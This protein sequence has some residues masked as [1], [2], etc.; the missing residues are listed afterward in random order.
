MVMF[1]SIVRLGA[2]LLALYVPIVMAQV[3][4]GMVV[5][6]I[7]ADDAGGIYTGSNVT[8][9]VIVKNTAAVPQ[10]WQGRVNIPAGYEFVVLTNAW[11][12]HM[13]HASSAASKAFLQ[14][15]DSRVANR[16]A[17]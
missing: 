6:S 5:S 11:T 14:R 4:P 3:P 2:L 10:P 13:P 12:V 16:Q 1:K 7:S 17:R 8:L 9:K 15:F